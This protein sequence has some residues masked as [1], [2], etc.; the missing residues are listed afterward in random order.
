VS[1]AGF[2]PG[3]T[4]TI[5]NFCGRR[6]DLPRALHQ[7][8]HTVPRSVFDWAILAGLGALV[9]VADEICNLGLRSRARR[10]LRIWTSF[11]RRPGASPLP[12]GDLKKGANDDERQP[13]NDCRRRPPATGKVL[14]REGRLALTAVGAVAFY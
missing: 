13:P 1:G 12:Q 5:P 7:L 4:S 10:P 2:E 3:E 14:R 6:C 8:L 9:L 11:G